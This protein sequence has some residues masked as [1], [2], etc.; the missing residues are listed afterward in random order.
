M[1]MECQLFKDTTPHPKG[2]DE[3]LNH[4]HTIGI[5]KATC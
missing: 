2:Q 5:T 3:A 1:M 4:K